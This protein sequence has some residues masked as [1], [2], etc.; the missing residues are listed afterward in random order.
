MFTRK[1]LISTLFLVI[2]ALTVPGL[3]HG[4]TYY[5]SPSG[6][7]S[8]DGLSSSYP[9]K[10]FSH[11]IPELDPGDTLIVMNGTYSVAAGTG[12]PSI[13][14]GT[15][16]NNGTEAQPI[17]IQAQNERAP[18]LESTGD[19]NTAFRMSGCSYWNVHGL[20]GK[21]ADLA[22]G[23]GGKQH[24]V[25]EISASNH[26][27]LQRLLATHNNRYF[28]S[29][30]ISVG[31][32]SYSLVEECEAYYFH[33]HGISIYRSDHITVRRCYVNSRGY[34]DIAEGCP[35]HAGAEGLGDEGMT[36]YQTTDSI[37]ENCISEGNEFF[38][39]SGQRNQYLGSIALNN[40]YGF[41]VGHHAAD[42]YMEARDNNYINNVALGS[43]YH[44][45]LTQ[46]DVNCF[47]D[48]LTSMNNGQNVYYGLY[49][50]NKY[51]DNRSSDPAV[52]WMVYPS[53]AV[54]N[55]LF[56]NN[57]DYGIRV[58]EDH[59]EDYVYRKFE[60]LNSYGHDVD[61]YGG[62]LTPSKPE[63]VLTELS[64]DDPQMGNCIVF[65]PT[66]T[67]MKGAGKYG[68]DIGAN[69]LYRYENG[70]LINQLL[71]NAGTGAFPC[72]AT[73]SGLNDVAGSSCINVHERLNVNANGCNL[74]TPQCP[75]SLVQYH[76]RWRN[77]NG[78]ESAATFMANQDTPITGFAKSTPVR[79]RFEVSNEG[80]TS[81]GEVAY[82]LQ[83]AQTSTCSSG[84]YSAVPTDAS[85]HWQIVDS[86]YITDGQATSNIT[87]GLTDEATTF[88]AGQ[89]KDTGNTTGSIT[90]AGDQFTEIE[91]AIQA[92]TNAIDGANYCFRLYN[93]TLGAPLNTYSKY[94]EAALAGGSTKAIYYSVG[95]DSN[96][97]YSGSAS[98]LNG[99]LTL[100]SAAADKIGVGDEVR[101][102]DN[103]YYI[104]RRNS[105]TSFNIQNSGANSGIPGDTNI[106]FSSTT[107][108]I[109]RA[110]GS[111]SAA[112]SGSSNSSHLKTSD[113][114]GGKY[115]L[116]WPCYADGVM[117]SSLTL[118]QTGYTT[119]P[120]N[121][122]RIY[123]PT[124][125]SE[126]GTSQRHNGTWNTGFMMIPSSGSAISVSED[127]VRIE[128]IAIQATSAA[129]SSVISVTDNAGAFSDNNDVRISHC[130]IVGRSG[131]PNSR[132]VWVSDTNNKVNVTLSNTIA[133]NH[134]TTG[135]GFA[136]FQFGGT[137]TGFNTGYCYNCTA[138]KNRYGFQRYGTAGGNFIL[139]NCIS[140]GNTDN[141]YT[142]T[143]TD[144]DYNMSSNTS[145]PGAHSL[146][147]KTASN[148]FVSTASGSENHHLKYGADAI[149]AGTSLSSVFTNDIDGQV[150]SIPWDM[151]ADENLIGVLAFTERTEAAGFIL[152]PDIGG[153][154]GTY[155]V[156]YDG[157]GDEDL[158]M[159]SH[160]IG[161]N[162]NTGRNALFQNQ[163]DG[164][165]I[166]VA[167]TAGVDGGLHGRFTRELHGASWFDFDNDR[168]FDLF[169]P[170]TD[171]KANDTNYHAWDEIY[172]NNGDGTFTNVSISLGL[173]QLDYCRRG[174]VAGDFNNDGFLDLFAV[175]MIELNCV[176]DY[177]CTA[178]VP[179]PYRAVFI[180]NGGTSFSLEN[181]G[182]GYVSWSEGVTT[183]D[184]NG[185]G[186]VD[187]LVADETSGG[188]LQ[189]WRNNGTGNFTNVTASVGLPTGVDL[190]GS[191]IVGD[192][193]NDGDMDIY[194]SAGLYRNDGG[195]FTYQG[196]Y[197]VAEHMFFADLNNDGFLDLVS[198][199]IYLNNGDGTFG[200]DI[201]STLG[202]TCEGRGGMAFDADN[203]GDLDIIFNRSDRESPYLRYYRNDLNSG[204]W[205]KVLLIAP[206]G[207]IG[208]PGAKIWVYGEGHLGDSD[209]LLGYREVVTAGGFVSGPSPTQH[210]GLGGRTSVDMRVQYVTGE[211]EEKLSVSAQ[212]TY[213][214]AVKLSSFTARRQGD[215]V[216]VQWETKTEV[217]NLGFNLYRSTERDGTYTK[218]NSSLISGLI[219][220]VKGRKY[221]FTDSGLTK[222][223]RYYYKLEDIDL[224]GK[225]TVHGPVCVDWDRDGI[226]DD[227]DPEVRDS[228]SAAGGGSIGG[229]ISGGGGIPDG[230]SWVYGD[231][232]VTR[233]NLQGFKAH[234][235]QGGVLVEWQTGYEV[236]NLGFHLYR[237]VDGEV[238]RLTPELVA[239]SALL[240]GPGVSLQAGHQYRWLDTSVS[241][242]QLSALR[243]KLSAIKYW[244]ED[245]D[246]NG[247]KTMHGPVEVRPSALG[248]QLSASDYR[249][250]ELMSEFGKKLDKRYGEFW[251]VQKLKEKLKNVNRYTLLDK[252]NKTNNEAVNSYTLLGKT[253]NNTDNDSPITNNEA[254]RA[255]ANVSVSSVD[256]RNETPAGRMISTPLSDKPPKIAPPIQ[257]VLAANAAV[258]L[259]VKEE[260]WYRVSSSEL[261]AAGLSSRINP[262]SL[263]LYTEGVEVPL[264]V[265]SERQG[266]SVS[267]EA[268]EFYGVGMDTPS[269]DTRVYWLVSGSK[270]GKRIDIHTFDP[271]FRN[272][273]SAIRPALRG[274]Q[275]S[276]E[277]YVVQGAIRNSSESFPYTV[278][279]KDR[280]I[281]FAGLRNGDQSNFFG[282]I[283]YQAPADQILEVRHLDLAASGDAT[284]EVRVQGVT[285]LPHQVN[286]FVNEI[287]I[288]TLSWE[289]QSL[290]TEVFSVPHSYLEE[291]ENL[292]TFVPLGGE[293]DMSLVDSI[294]LT[295][296]RTY[297]AYEDELRCQ[298]QGGT[299]V[300]IDGFS[301]PEVRVFDI[302][303]AGG[304]FE[305]ETKGKPVDTGYG[306]TFRVPGSGTRTLLALTDQRMKT[307]AGIRANQPSSWRKAG[308]YDFVIVS[309]GDFID[310]L[311]SLE[312]LRKSEGL[313][314]GVMNIED[315]YDEF[316]FGM[317]SPQAL[318]DFLSHARSSWSRPPRFV[319]LVGDASFDP[320]NYLGFGDQD[321]VP[322]K[323]IDTVHLET[324][325][326][327]WFVD[328]DN[329][330]LPEMAIGRLPVQTAEEAATVVS[331]MIGY[332]KSGA[333]KEAILVADRT[334]GP[335]DF[336][337]EGA[338]EGVRA[339]LPAPILVRK[340]FRG[341]FSSDAQAK[342]ELLLGINQG[343][344][345]VN[346]MGHG[347]LEVW[348]GSLLTAGDA[349]SLINGLQLLF[350]VN[351]TCLNG[352][353]QAPYADSMAEALLKAQGGGAIAIWASSGMTEPGGQL[354]M[355]E[356]LVRQLF[357]GEGLTIGEAV[358][359]AKASVTDM[360]IRKTW[361]LFGDPATRLRAG[362]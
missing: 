206:N 93:T 350:F 336:D 221:S 131:S 339:L 262:Q 303:D 23:D 181:W 81:S 78:N 198:G 110:F 178:S 284:L 302:T 170:N 210:F 185:D 45:F 30:A 111:L 66:G 74:G 65:I 62:G 68:E 118:S 274:M 239:G 53:L 322:T 212:S 1:A 323:L 44:G 173:P 290:K 305:V 5:I 41:V 147:N 325:S 125:P 98:A 273:Q 313:S 80:G 214:T 347:S 346:F 228:D 9:W 87:P 253:N 84:T 135:S 43:T 296:W 38:G 351:M 271:Q 24:S 99:V 169:M 316:N 359:K 7:D 187:I 361:I 342:G 25:F 213:V 311:S 158:F 236:D 106:T 151:G 126:V 256:E 194:C 193:D 306:V 165:F 95:T 96:P 59:V 163:G 117:T 152:D 223:K 207:Q 2:V 308:G 109:Y 324:A 149:N 58:N 254:R 294:R 314:V 263:R 183:L 14:C 249:R 222:G 234:E 279:K 266:R 348:R 133:Y 331:K 148:N 121:Y 174:G 337:F 8:N 26:I 61:N 201:S 332:E 13:S 71:W 15:N 123:T 261:Q 216:L 171:S 334:E 102:G 55:T 191:V 199:G 312:A 82:Q 230:G 252:T 220:S 247:K 17:T 286:V 189:L 39:N 11:A 190:N 241:S 208:A 340:I 202:V 94:A 34:S 51:S 115:Q 328:F 101:V 12:L 258:K 182:I 73:V 161:Q 301:T 298:A 345:L 288:G 260:G 353:F 132:A 326:D 287:G 139:T 33:R 242:L 83:V 300:S 46:S 10:T 90:L 16:A 268:I 97:L 32:S 150:R 119:G 120:D 22:T 85:G 172:R 344:L 282:P 143:F 255:G 240:A 270:P 180:N 6:S 114:V 231:S 217:E 138:Y 42:G 40:L 29:Q 36:F 91:F 357:N 175:N 179:S 277:P 200:S 356:E 205:L 281:Y 203:D 60:Y 283:I 264:S 259:L 291:G 275:G 360:D 211:V 176:S 269:T 70:I 142:G 248:S 299:Q 103:R 338:S 130:L 159:T 289:G 88:V 76:Y 237:E 278:E 48:H 309:H 49:S 112:Y 129:A 250:A 167:Q 232:T 321:Y 292:V 349:E 341:Q 154:H 116:N 209:Y 31:N 196:I 215:T 251:R 280:I 127:Y 204:T 315:V 89:L 140:L 227:V 77:D 128:G 355:N 47:V 186:Y 156:D 54:Q 310:S 235:T 244:L 333:K 276:P 352:F 141:D 297:R 225:K 188:G 304:V 197:G 50:N 4:A 20:R 86:S 92:T 295:Y 3:S 330:G 293:T 168:D 18:L 285:A 124:S 246:L 317:K 52:T 63:D 307:P 265:I 320:R 146:H 28:N 184:Y 243:S 354:M 267:W 318:K 245:I 75:V 257:Q 155:V 362:Y 67:P 157:D 37:N 134:S 160:G 166:E 113:L 105:S 358:M 238:V 233:V 35:S 219:S 192:I 21:S 108:S 145:A 72:G 319:L 329:D 177:D 327:D 144:S 226:P 153:W 27:K 56:L 100:G 164:T 335:N 122:I 19:D 272:P 107:I 79:L 343:P 137:D 218:L 69:I 195:Y 64:E 136:A 57:G 104:T 162:P 224:K 229:G